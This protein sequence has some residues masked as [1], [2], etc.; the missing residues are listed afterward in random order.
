MSSLTFGVEKKNMF[1]YQNCSCDRLFTE[2]IALLWRRVIGDVV[3]CIFGCRTMSVGPSEISFLLAAAE[4]FIED[5]CRT[6]MR[7]GGNK[8]GLC[9]VI[10]MRSGLY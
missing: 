4:Y 3:Y 6:K 9:D 7:N 10:V 5:V 1:Y 8:V 2:P